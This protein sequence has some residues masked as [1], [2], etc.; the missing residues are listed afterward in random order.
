MSEFLVTTAWL[1]ENLSSPGLVVLDCSWHLPESGLSGRREFE[2]RHIPGA[3]YLDLSDIS[4]RAS[5]YV[6]MMPP[7][8]QFAAAVSALG[9]TNASQVVVYDAG[10]VSARVWW[11]FRA[12]G[13]RSVRILD[14]G[15]RKWQAE[16]RPVRTGAAEAP[17][18]GNFIPGGTG[19][20]VADWRAVLDAQRSGSATIVDARTAERFTGALPSGYPGVPGGH[21]PGSVNVP[22]SRFF[23]EDF[24]YVSPERARELLTAAGVDLA[25][26]VIATCGSGI[27]ASILMLML[28]RLSHPAA[29]LY[30]GSW[31][32]WGQR[33]D[34]PKESV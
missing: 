3:R 18:P 27:T 2:E 12:F 23:G 10:Y 29:S 7:A 30:D 1:A 31:H 34:L 25:R 21:I 5:P 16:G 33:P 17:P 22:W 24:S 28:E 26:P 19:G 32:E 15:L 11:M 4:D 14:G 6:N 13:H 20:T 8:G 9:V